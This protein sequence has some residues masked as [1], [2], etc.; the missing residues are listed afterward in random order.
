MTDYAV[1]WKRTDGATY[2]NNGASAGCIISGTSQT[3]SGA[4]G[5]GTVITLTTSAAHNYVVGQVVTV[6]GATPAGYNGKYAIRSVPSSTTF[7]MNGA[8]TGALTQ[9]GTVTPNTEFLVDALNSSETP[10]AGVKYDINV[11]IVS[12]G[13]A[14]GWTSANA[15]SQVTPVT[16]TTTVTAPTGTIDDTKTVTA[17]GST[18]TEYVKQLTY[19]SGW[20]GIIVQTANASWTSMTLT[21][22]LFGVA[23]PRTVLKADVSDKNT[24][25][26]TVPSSVTVSVS[27]LKTNNATVNFT[28]TTV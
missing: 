20:T 3:V 27:I 18:A 11:A 4:S 8:A 1:R 12:L 22:Y 6:S 28:L 23:K 9:N 25:Y 19:S 13:V 17:S 16:Y 7:T 21:Y 10:T 26:F 24:V 14:S 15:L 5:T 2:F